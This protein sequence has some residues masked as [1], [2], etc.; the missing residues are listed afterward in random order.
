MA[1]PPR[2]FEA[3]ANAFTASPWAYNDRI[4]CLSEDGDCFVAEHG[5]DFRLVGKNSIGELCMS[6]PAIS[7]GSLLL[8]TAENLYRIGG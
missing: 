3:G 8:R 1:P 5:R 2:R 7:Q 4:F 6:T